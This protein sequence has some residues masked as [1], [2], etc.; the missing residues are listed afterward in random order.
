M[1]TEASESP[2]VRMQCPAC[3]ARVRG[4]ADAF[5]EDVTCPAC[6]EQRVFRRAFDDAPASDASVERSPSTQTAPSRSRIVM[7]ATAACLAVACLAAWMYAFSVQSTRETELRALEARAATADAERE[8]AACARFET[9]LADAVAMADPFDRED[10]LRALLD[11]ATMRGRPEATIAT[12]RAALG[13][14][15]DAVDHAVRV[16]KAEDARDAELRALREQVEQLTDALA[17]RD[18]RMESLE[19][20]AAQLRA[21]AERAEETARNA[22]RAA[23]DREARVGEAL[24]RLDERESAVAERERTLADTQNELALRMAAARM[25]DAVRDSSP[26]PVT[27]VERRPSVSVTHVIERTSPVVFASPWWSFSHHD[28]R[29]HR[30][31]GRISVGKRLDTPS[32]SVSK[33]GIGSLS[34]RKYV[35]RKD[36]GW[37][38]GGAPLT[39]MSISNLV[40]AKKNA[41]AKK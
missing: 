13:R 14:A 36:T 8:A 2:T 3:G 15:R 30:R 33:T 5:A 25:A 31:Y 28:D 34:D 22:A 21:R 1:F 23:A 11:T 39:S 26:P 10:A 12:V 32:W 35:P 29:H 6:G 41:A 19:A 9:M 24:A 16:R 7:A 38:I 17:A 37:S 20:D 40:E 4:P 18:D 27:V